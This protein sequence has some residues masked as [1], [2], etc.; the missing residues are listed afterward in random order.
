MQPEN[1]MNTD[2]SLK[3]PHPAHVLGMPESLV[4]L[5]RNLPE[6]AVVGARLDGLL[7]SRAPDE[8]IRSFRDRLRQ[9]HGPNPGL[10]VLVYDLPS[11]H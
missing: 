4:F 10:A 3:A 2:P 11:I 8:D 1:A 7:H 6:S 5:A 9:A